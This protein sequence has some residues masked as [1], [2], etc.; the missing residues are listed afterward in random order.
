MYKISYNIIIVK[1]V[2]KR[3]LCVLRIS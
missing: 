3:T 1:S 2:Q